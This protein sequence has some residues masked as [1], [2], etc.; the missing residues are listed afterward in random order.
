MSARRALGLGLAVL[1]AG[2]LGATAAAEMYRCQGPD[3][4]TLFTGD[5]SQCPGAAPFEP[6]RDVQR[7]ESARVPEPERSTRRSAP[8]AG[9]D[10]AARAARWK[11]KRRE[12]EA[13]LAEVEGALDDLVQAVTW[14]NQGREVFTTDR[15]TGLRRTLSCDRLRAQHEALRGERARLEAYLHEG[16][17]EE[18]CRRAGCLPGWIR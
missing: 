4:R 10:E 3:G 11:A 13:R 2:G 15:E 9:L 14:C 16:G 18:E 5:P 8:P 12:S 1:L 17:L 6:E 7:A